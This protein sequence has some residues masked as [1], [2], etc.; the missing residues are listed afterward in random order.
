MK[1]FLVMIERKPTFT[2]SLLQGHRE[3]LGNL[4]GTSL[5]YAGGFEDQSGG[6]YVIQANSLEEAQKI[7]SNDPMNEENETVYKLK[8]WN[9]S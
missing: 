2:G 9:F 1:K 4:K 3:F 7:V 8:Q 6:A 5:V